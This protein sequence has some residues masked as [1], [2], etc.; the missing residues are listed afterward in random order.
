[1]LYIIGDLHLSAMNPWNYEI[2]ENFIKW[3][4][5]WVAN[6]KKEDSNPHLLWLGDI[7][8]KDV[9]PGDV[10]DQEF[11]IFQICS[12]NFITTHVIMGNHDIKLYRQKA[13][14]SLKFLR[15]FP[16]VSV[17]DK[18]IDVNISNTKVRMLPH[19]R[20][21]GRTLSEY[22]STMT[23]RTDV[24]LVVGHWN[25]Y[26]PSSPIQGG[27]KT[28]NMRTKALCLGHVHTRTDP[29]YTGSVFPNKVD[30]IG[31]RVIKVFND[32]AF[33][34]EIELPQFV[35]Y[36]SIEYPKEIVEPQDGKVHI[37][38]V[39]GISNITAAKSFYK[40]HFIRG[41][42][43]KKIDKDQTTGFISDDVFMYKD[44]YQAFNDWLKETKYPLSRKAAAILSQI[45][46][47]NVSA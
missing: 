17:V 18:P 2:S 36:D 3:F 14:H 47:K 5:T 35:S 9:N 39:E 6:I 12:N 24:D 45:L 16:N 38:T 22:Y 30:E 34:K 11:R 42:L 33:V 8:E 4:E 37:Y 19:V 44:N 15:N 26:D 41:V 21:Q 32:G 31:Q 23:F 27:V 29:D 40:D 43:S 20:V 10:I 1:M 7:T 46:K 25:K 13:Q 28:D